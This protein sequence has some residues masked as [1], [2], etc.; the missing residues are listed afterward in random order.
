MPPVSPKS[1]PPPK[2][3]QPKPRQSPVQDGSPRLAIRPNR[4]DSLPSDS[5]Q[6]LQAR[7]R[8]FYE[9]RIRA[10]EQ[11][12]GETTAQLTETLAELIEARQV[13]DQQVALMQKQI[14]DLIEANHKISGLASERKGSLEKAIRSQVG[15]EIARQL[16]AL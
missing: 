12:L 1:A 5:A 3:P 2:A 15:K 9:Q 8:A 14:S 6:A 11:Q 4:A 7:E 10:L 16:E 13:R